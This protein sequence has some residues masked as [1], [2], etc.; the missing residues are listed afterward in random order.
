MRR[1]S[2][3]FLVGERQSEQTLSFE[4]AQH[5]HYKY[6]LDNILRNVR[7][8]YGGV[9]ARGIDRYAPH[10]RSSKRELK[11]SMKIVRTAVSNS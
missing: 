6:Y 5:H 3:S 8:C 1:S 7:E 11:R 4:K 10:I 9:H 2:T